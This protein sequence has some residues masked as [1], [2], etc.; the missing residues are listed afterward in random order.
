M[1]KKSH[2]VSNSKVPKKPDTRK[3]RSIIPTVLLFVTVLIFISAVI[4]NYMHSKTVFQSLAYK[5]VPASGVGLKVPENWMQMEHFATTMFHDSAMNQ[6]DEPA[7]ITVSTH[8]SLLIDLSS[9]SKQQIHE[10]LELVVNKLKANSN[11][12]VNYTNIEISE[13]NGNDVILAESTEKYGYIS[14]TKKAISIFMVTKTGEVKR[15]AIVVND[16]LYEKNRAV[17]YKIARSARL[18]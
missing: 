12:V 18:L 6:D 14:T 9:A 11:S 1:P 7:T 5:E 16:D 4:M 3:K 10:Q 2:R 8:E 17:M 13:V 15:V